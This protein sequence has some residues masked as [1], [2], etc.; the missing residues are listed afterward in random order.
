MKR[1]YKS[2]ALPALMAV[3][4]LAG[5][6]KDDALVYV[7]GGIA[8]VLTASTTTPVMDPKKETDL[9]MVFYW[10]NPNYQ[11]TTGLSSQDVQYSLEIDT[12]G[13]NFKNPRKG[14]VVLSKDLS[15]TFTAY[16]L[17]VILSGLNFMNLPPDIKYNFE[18]R[19]VSSIKNALPMTSNVI[20]FS[21][22]P[23]SPPPVVDVPTA[24]TLWATG[25]AF[26]SGWANPLGS[27][28]DVTQQFTRV[29]NTLYQLVVDMP[30][31]G[32]Y[33]LI[34]KQ[35]EWGTQ[36]RMLEGGTWESGG[37][38]K[39]DADPGFI[40]PPTPGR[41]KLTFNFQNGTF[42]VVKQ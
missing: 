28:Y 23:F 9:A 26:A 37:F 3:L 32:N 30:S 16:D 36:Y 33:K 13:S 31:G 40:G 5:C 20:K 7:E 8:P 19:V 39:Q 11:F 38:K 35:G 12:V 6:K 24:G 10:T 18:A 41:Y 4:A 1:L 2:L 42:T 34:Q 22:T 17:N 14:V 15:K 27:P 21:A 25:N 29:T